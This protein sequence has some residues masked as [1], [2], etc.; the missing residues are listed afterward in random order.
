MEGEQNDQGVQGYKTKAIQGCKCEGREA[1]A[2]QK[3]SRTANMRGKQTTRE[4]RERGHMRG[5]KR[6]DD[7]C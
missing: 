4:P 1:S 3:Q 7:N 5:F 6:Q 2:K